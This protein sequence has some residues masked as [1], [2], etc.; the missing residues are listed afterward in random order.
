MEVDTSDG[1]MDE[2]LAL[3]RADFDAA[4]LTLAQLRGTLAEEE[5]CVN[6]C[7]WTLGRRLEQA[8]EALL[9]LA[10]VRH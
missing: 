5:E 2:A 10:G 6:T 8:R 7:N 4:S 3:A 1:G 9:E